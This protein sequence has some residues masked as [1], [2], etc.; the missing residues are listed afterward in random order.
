M[1]TL[2]VFYYNNNIST[3]YLPFAVFIEMIIF[4]D[5]GL[6]NKCSTR[7]PKSIGTSLI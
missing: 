7:A 6:A 5:V 2:H 3:Q 1:K 4:Y